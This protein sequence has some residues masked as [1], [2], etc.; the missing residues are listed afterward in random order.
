MTIHWSISASSVLIVTLR[1][2]HTE[3]ETSELLKLFWN[4][5]RVAQLADA[6][7]LKSAGFLG[8]CGFDSHPGHSNR[9]S[10]LISRDRLSSCNVAPSSDLRHAGSEVACTF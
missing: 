10:T 8:S 9:C 2:R 5:A 6:A 4:D 7:L 3:P 1:R